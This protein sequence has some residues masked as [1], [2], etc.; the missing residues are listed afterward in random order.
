MDKWRKL[1][2]SSLAAAVIATAGC[3]ATA[4][5]KQIAAK[6]ERPAPK[7]EVV[8]RAGTGIG[9]R[10]PAEK[11]S[12]AENAAGTWK[13][14]TTK[15][16]D[17][18]RS[19]PKV[20][21]HEDPVSLNSDPGPINPAIY[22]ATAQILEKS[23]RIDEAKNQYG[24][25]VAVAPNDKEALI[26]FARLHDRQ[27]EFA[28][29]EKFYARAIK[30]HPQHAEFYN[31]LGL[32]LARQKKTRQAADV[33]AK[34]VE[35]DPDKALFHNNLATVLV[36]LGKHDEAL[37]H[38]S[39]AQNESIAH[40]NLGYLLFRKNENAAAIRHLKIARQ[41]NP[42]FA[43]ASQMLARLEAR[44]P[45]VDPPT[46]RISD[47]SVVAEHGAERIPAQLTSSFTLSRLPVT[48]SNESYSDSSQTPTS[49]NCQS[50][51]SPNEPAAQTPLRNADQAKGV[52]YEVER[53]SADTPPATQAGSL[54]DHEPAAESMDSPESS[55]DGFIPAQPEKMIPPVPAR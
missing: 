36:D 44:G 4:P 25:A 23:G 5:F 43:Q 14:M 19:K 39:A 34:A 24:K 17:S 15:V 16:A 52:S 29:A 47:N 35:A 2:G 40:Y 10:G 53:P 51:E 22:V 31:D 18:L 30:A 45:S 49:E 21:K 13:S 32:C 41:L 9:H 1:F 55:G 33:L 27:G 46:Y 42:N 26:G 38:F 50:T 20:K 37:K 8:V 11:K 12:F 6:F 48:E 7:K 3:S 28:D 54:T